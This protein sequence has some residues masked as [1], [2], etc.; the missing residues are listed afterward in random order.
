MIHENDV[1]SK[2]A[3]VL[4]GEVS[5]VEFSRWIADH[6][7]NMHKDSAPNAIDLVSDIHILLAEYNDGAINNEVFFQQMERLSVANRTP[8]RARDP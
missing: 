2:M 4:S 1:R 5:L 8:D 6:S 3:A 7:W